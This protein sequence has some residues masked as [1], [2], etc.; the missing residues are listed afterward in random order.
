MQ[1]SIIPLSDAKNM[2]SISKVEAELV[3]N[4]ALLI[5]ID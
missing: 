5:A 2:V 3:L 4:A 1:F